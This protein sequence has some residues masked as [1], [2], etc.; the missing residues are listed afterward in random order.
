MPYLKL[1][2]IVHGGWQLARAAL[3]AKT[4][5][6]A[7]QGNSDFDN[8]KVTT[9]S[10]FAEH[11]MPYFEGPVNARSISLFNE[12]MQVQFGLTPADDDRADDR[13]A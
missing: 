10:F 6:A 1:A 5:L 2:G 3:A 4:R 9:A 13:H 12:L 7:N 8:A 11:I